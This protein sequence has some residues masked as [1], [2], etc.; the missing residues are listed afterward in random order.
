MSTSQTLSAS[1]ARRIALAASGFAAKRHDAPGPR[2]VRRVLSDLGQLQIDSVNVYERA[3]YL[4]LLSRLGPYPKDALDSLAGRHSIEYWPHQAGLIPAED[5]PLWQWRRDEYASG[6]RQMWLQHHRDLADWLLSELGEHGAVTAGAIE[7]DRN[8]SRG[9]WWGW[10]DVKIALE[11][12]WRTGEV[13]CLRRKNFERL[14]ELPSALPAAALSAPLDAPAAQRELL[15]R[16]ARALGV[17]TEADLADYWRMPAAQVR[18]VIA[19]FVDAG[20][21]EPVRVQGWQTANGRNIP[22]WLHRDSRTPRAITAATVLSPFDPLVWFRPRAERLF[23]FEYRIEIYTPAEKR[24]F[25]YYS[26]PILLGDNVVGRVDL[27][28]D[29]QRR[30]LLVQSAWSEEHAPAE[31]GERLADIVRDAARWQGLERVK[32]AGSGNL[33]RAL[34]QEFELTAAVEP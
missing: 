33:A 4:P 14:Y 15:E 13:V 12:L 6:R 5:W 3:H 30:D 23:N 34:P 29:R 31:L 27:K 10:S 9:A 1:Q 8:Q 17:F 22:A 21:I 25:G 26:L 18:P 2:Q 16:A 24:Q 32:N 20:T 19:E 7:H 28:S 11:Y